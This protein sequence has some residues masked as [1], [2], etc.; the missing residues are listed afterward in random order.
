MRRLGALTVAGVA[1]A[2]PVG[3]RTQGCC[4]PGV[5]Q[6]HLAERSEDIRFADQPMHSG[7]GDKEKP[8]ERLTPTR[9]HGGI[10]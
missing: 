10:Q 2:V 8:D 9:I 7:R 3:G 5:R 1:L 4:E 6:D